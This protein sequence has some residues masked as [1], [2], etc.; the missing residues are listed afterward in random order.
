MRV[1]K[2][3][4]I[5]RTSHSLNGQRLLFMVLGNAQLAA[6]HFEQSKAFGLIRLGTDRLLPFFGQLG[7]SGR[8]WLFFEPK[9]PF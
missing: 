7:E 9:D 1:S 2:G 6:V 4:K 8:V 5:V 3:Y